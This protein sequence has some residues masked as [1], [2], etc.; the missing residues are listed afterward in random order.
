MESP[1][2]GR[3]TIRELLGEAQEL[4][5]IDRRHLL[6]TALERS[7]GWLFA[8]PEHRPD[9]PLVERYR[10]WLE[11]RRAGEPVAYLE[12]RRAFWTLELAVDRRTLIPRPETELLVERGLARIAGLDHPR[13]LDL[14]TGSGA[15]ALAIASERPDAEIVAT[16]ASEDA[17]AVARANVRAVG[18][19]NVRLARGQWYEAVGTAR[20]DLIVSNPPYLAANDPHLAVGDLRAEPRRALVS[21]PSGLE[22]IHA[23]IERAPIHL[24]H[25]GALAIEHGWTQQPAVMA[26]CRAA[27]LVE[28][29][30]HA[31]LGGQPRVVEARMP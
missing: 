5:A 28:V 19:D 7:A 1:T 8:H 31:D 27:G 13:V 24:D 25:A 15:I 11:R 2:G 22:A 6:A 30:G 26:A 12:G 23:I 21:G 29:I 9:A 17:L 20:F 4:D 10:G 14:G 18:A 16:D 3:P